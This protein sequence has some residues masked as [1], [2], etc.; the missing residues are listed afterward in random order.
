MPGPA[1]HASVAMAPKL[2]SGDPVSWR[3]SQGTVRGK[4]VKTLTAKTKIKGHVAKASKEAP[5][6][7]VA[8]DKT[9]AK[10]AHKPAAL[11]KA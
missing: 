8:S 6:V 10:A 3:A 7:L 5:Q 9:G 2:K 11:K 1:Q 4:V